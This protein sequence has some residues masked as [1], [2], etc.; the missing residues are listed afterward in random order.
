MTPVAAKSIDTML[1]KPIQMNIFAN[2]GAIPT[3]RGDLADTGGSIAEQRA[4]S[5]R[6]VSSNRIDR[7]STGG[8]IAKPKQGAK[9]MD[10][11]KTTMTAIAAMAQKFAAAQEAARQNI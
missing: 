2:I 8:M 11:D 4:E 9:S 6:T 1:R 10:T 3:N 7:P 5:L